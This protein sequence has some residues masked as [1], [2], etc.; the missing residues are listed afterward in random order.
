MVDSIIFSVVFRSN[1]VEQRQGKKDDKKRF[2]IIE[3]FYSEASETIE[4]EYEM[5]RKKYKSPKRKLCDI[6][7]G[8]DLWNFMENSN[9][10]ISMEV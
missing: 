3:K 9:D 6:D 7:D 1:K 2:E 10:G 8:E 5:Q 4:K